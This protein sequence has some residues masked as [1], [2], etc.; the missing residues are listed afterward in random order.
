[1][2]QVLELLA[3]QHDLHP[4]LA[5]WGN[6]G[7]STPLL[8]A[9]QHVS[10]QFSSCEGDCGGPHLGLLLAEQH[11]SAATVMMPSPLRAM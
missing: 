2:S 7:V 9:E 4:S 5:V 10:C 3:E 11:A 6:S 8:L 1:M